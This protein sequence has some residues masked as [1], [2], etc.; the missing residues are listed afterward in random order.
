MIPVAPQVIFIFWAA[1][2]G[3]GAA[4]GLVCGFLAA[5]AFQLD[6]IGL[7]K[8]ALLGGIGVFAGVIVA[9]RMPWPEN[10]VSTVASDGRVVQT[11]MHQF[12][13]PFVVAYA[14]AAVLPILHQLYRSRRSS[15]KRANG[16]TAT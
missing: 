13:H 6:R 14:F 5:R 9:I 4:I 11:T 16:S 10:T 12:Q 15:Q 8:D 2:T 3:A 1:A 7:W